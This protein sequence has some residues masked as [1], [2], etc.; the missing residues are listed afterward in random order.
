MFSLISGIMSSRKGA[1]SK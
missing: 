1:N